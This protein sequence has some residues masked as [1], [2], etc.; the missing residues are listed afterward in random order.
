MNVGGQN[1]GR[2]RR[3]QHDSASTIAEQHAGAAV[4][5][6]ED[7]A[8]G[9]G[10][11]DK[12]GLGLT[13]DDQSIGIGQRI[14]KA[15]ANRLHIKGKTVGHAQPFLHHG[16][17]G[18]KSKIRSRGGHDDAVDILDADPGLFKRGLSC[19]ND[20]SVACAAT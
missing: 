16:A 13:G 11:D 4:G 5:P 9:L 12:D 8:E 10:A 7:A 20:G 2:I 1:T 14:D 6:V 17:D 15:R 18:R 19:A 3:F